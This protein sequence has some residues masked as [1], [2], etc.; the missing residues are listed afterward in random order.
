LQ[1]LPIQLIKSPGR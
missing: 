1:G